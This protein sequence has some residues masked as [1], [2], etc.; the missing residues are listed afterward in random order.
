MLK[1]SSD[2]KTDAC[3]AIENQPA[4]IREALEAVPAE[5]VDRFYGCGSPIPPALEGCT[6]L[7]L[8]C[9]TGR[10]AYVCARFVGEHGHVIGVD[11][12]AEQIEVAQRNEHAYART[13]GYSDPNTTFLQGYMENLAGLGID[14]ETIDVVI[15]NCVINLSPDKE[16]VFSEIFRVLK[17]GGELLFA[18]VFADRRLP[19][20]WFEDPVLVGECLAGAMYVE[21]FRR[22]LFGLGVP[23]YR[24]VSSRPIRLNNTEIERKVGSDRFSSVTARA[25]K[26][27]S[28]EDRCEDYG[29]VAYYRG[30]IPEMPHSFRLDDHH[31]FVTEKPMLVCGNTAAM[32]GETRFG[33]HFRVEGDHSRHFGLF[34][35]GPA[36]STGSARQD[37]EPGGCC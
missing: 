4:H 28:I 10:D 27:A 16:R 33:R 11:M 34:P 36:E 26:L 37:F 35:C 14:D 9:G 31:E 17:P 32:V 6:V 21:D 22:M 29:Q 24:I 25:F 30:T 13:L 1:S 15:S 8:G 12:T 23:D 5:I 3:C 18:D 7:D 19:A 2:L 20:E